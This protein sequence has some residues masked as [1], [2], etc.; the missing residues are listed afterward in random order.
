ML[1]ELFHYT[2]QNPSPADALSVQCTR[3]Y[4]E[5]C[6]KIFERGLLSHTKVT[7]ESS[8]VLKSIDE[9]YLF[10]LTWLESLV[11]NYGIL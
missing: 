10:F 9:G 2:S 8:D 6:S 3:K 1:S 4:L 5:A 7:D 11:K